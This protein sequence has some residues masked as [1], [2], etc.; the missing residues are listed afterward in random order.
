MNDVVLSMSKTFKYR[1]FE[2]EYERGEF[3]PRKNMKKSEAGRKGGE[4]TARTHGREFYQEIG[5][6]GGKKAGRR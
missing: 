5:R 2:R 6:K 1:D 4:A 3:M